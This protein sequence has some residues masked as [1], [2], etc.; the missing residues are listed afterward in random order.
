VQIVALGLALL[1]PSALLALLLVRRN[2]QPA[3]QR[4]A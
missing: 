2:G 1:I 4:T 3:L